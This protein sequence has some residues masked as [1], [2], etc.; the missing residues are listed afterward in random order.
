MPRPWRP[1]NWEETKPTYE[2]KYGWNKVPEQTDINIFDAGVE[3]GADA[4]AE[5]VGTILI[6]IGAALQGKV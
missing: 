5:A 2:K 1:E 3:A 6:G 4:L